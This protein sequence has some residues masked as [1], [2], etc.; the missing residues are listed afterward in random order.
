MEILR[1]YGLGTNLN[2][3]LQRYWGKQVVVTKTGKF[4]GRPFRMER[5]VT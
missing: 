5:G 1:G 2:K 3:L 4:F